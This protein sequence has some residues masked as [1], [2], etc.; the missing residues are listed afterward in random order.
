MGEIYIPPTESDTE[1]DKATDDI[2]YPGK[3]TD[4]ESDEIMDMGDIAP[5]N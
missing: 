5:E 1:S 3:I 2:E 4:V